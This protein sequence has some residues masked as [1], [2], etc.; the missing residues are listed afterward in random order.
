VGKGKFTLNPSAT[1]EYTCRE[2]LCPQKSNNI[3]V[4]NKHELTHYRHR[5]FRD[6]DFEHPPS[7]K[8]KD[9][10]VQIFAILGETLLINAEG[11]VD[12]VF[13][14]FHLFLESRRNNLDL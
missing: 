13:M 3:N 4:K 10:F 1:A 5:F 9:E 12:L 2:T 8:V 7:C 6:G 14:H 11:K